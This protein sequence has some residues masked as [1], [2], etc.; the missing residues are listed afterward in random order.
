MKGINKK[1]NTGFGVLIVLLVFSEALSMVELSKADG[2]TR[3]MLMPGAITLIVTVS[4]VIVFWFLINYYYVRPTLRIQRR[5]QD[6]L[7]H[8]IPF[9]PPVEG[10]DEI[11][12]L[13]ENIETLI[14]MLKSKQ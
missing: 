11:S 12:R 8:N 9:N 4:I 13:K 6:Y 7:R 3:S 1:I 5:L 14:S 10:H 2:F